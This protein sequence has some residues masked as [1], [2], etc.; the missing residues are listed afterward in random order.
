M[1]GGGEAT[2]LDNREKPHSTKDA[3]NTNAAQYGK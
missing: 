1:F 2:T 3:N